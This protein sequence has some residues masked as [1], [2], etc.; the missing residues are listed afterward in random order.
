MPPNSEYMQVKLWAMI[1]LSNK[2]D[3]LEI[4]TDSSS[5]WVIMQSMSATSG[6]NRKLLKCTYNAELGECSMC[7]PDSNTPLECV[8]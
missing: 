4:A 5:V 6:L 1:V 8:I 7:T 2:T 3:A